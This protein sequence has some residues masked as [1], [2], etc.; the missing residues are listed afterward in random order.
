MGILVAKDLD[1]IYRIRNHAK[2]IM[3]AIAEA[4]NGTSALSLTE[5][6]LDEVY[7]WGV[8]DERHGDWGERVAP[9]EKIEAKPSGGCGENK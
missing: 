2:K 7:E 1:Q 5:T 3:H 6:L 9:V 4:P 8:L